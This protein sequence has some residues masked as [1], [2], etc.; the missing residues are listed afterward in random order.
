[1]FV[2]TDT[3]SPGEAFPVT[4]TVD[5]LTVYHT[6]DVAIGCETASA[7]GIGGGATEK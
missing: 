4:V 3:D 6:P 2:P 5:E 7:V 1:M